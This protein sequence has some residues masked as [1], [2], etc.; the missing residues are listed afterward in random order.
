MAD[1]DQGGTSSGSAVSLLDLTRFA[2]AFAD[3]DDPEAMAW[4]WRR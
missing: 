4:A 3:L 1:S 2:E